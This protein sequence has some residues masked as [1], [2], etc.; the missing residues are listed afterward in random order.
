MSISQYR[1][2]AK[3]HERGVAYSI[4]LRQDIGN[5]ADTLARWNRFEI[6][7]RCNAPG[8]GFVR[9]EPHEGRLAATVKLVILDCETS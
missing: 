6:C 2:R 1:P 5:A 7:Y 3:Y 4:V 9:T 8:A